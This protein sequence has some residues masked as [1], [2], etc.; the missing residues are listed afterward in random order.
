MPGVAIVKGTRNVEAAR[1]WVDFSLS[2]EGQNVSFE[3]NK[4]QIQSN[5]SAKLHPLAPKPDEV[6]IAQNYDV[7]GFASEAS[8]TRI[9]DKFEKEVKSL[10]K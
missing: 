3:M 5:K 4:F 7:M 9:L 8:R 6:K 1:K 10:P 2:L